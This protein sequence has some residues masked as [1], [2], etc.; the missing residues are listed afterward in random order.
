MNCLKKTHDNYLENYILPRISEYIFPNYNFV[1]FF[2]DSVYEKCINVR[3]SYIKQLLK[4]NYKL[5]EHNLFE[6]YPIDASNNK[7][8]IGGYI[9]NLP[10]CRFLE[11]I[12]NN[13]LFLKLD[14][15]SSN[16]ELNFLSSILREKLKFENLI[17]VFEIENHINND[18][19]KLSYIIYYDDIVDIDDD[20]WLQCVQ[21]AMTELTLI[22]SIEHAIWHLIVAHI[23]YIIK[24]KL[25]FS[26]IAKVFG[27]ASDNVFIKA[28]EVKFLLFGTPLVFGQILNNNEE[29][30]KYLNNKI[31]SFINDF[32]ID[33]IFEDYFNLNNINPDLNWCYGMKD[34]IEIIKNF[35]NNIILEKD[36]SNENKIIN[37]Y[38][39]KKYKNNKELTNIPDIKKLLE[40]LFVVG[41][42]FH[43]TTFEFTKIIMTDL[44]YHPKLNKLFY[45]ISIQ[46]IVA[47]IT[48]L[49]GDEELYKGKIYKKVISKL[50]EDLESSRLNITNDCRNNIYKNNIYCTKDIMRNKYSPHTYTTYV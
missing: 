25:Y 43:S 37:N 32:N 3:K 48:Y 12:D 50:K 38:L 5:S 28:L 17:L 41:S 34:N 15:K 18:F 20:N 10:Y 8:L 39:I 7:R 9:S 44:F 33:T 27:I 16:K 36:I 40:I 30:K 42:A 11:K 46:T 21:S 23:I 47:D 1:D 4:K 6:N 35:V 29:F 19:L 24:R 49:F 31:T 26:E 13:N 2:E 45:G 22:L 14:G